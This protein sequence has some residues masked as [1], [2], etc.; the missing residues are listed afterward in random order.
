MPKTPPPVPHYQSHPS[1]QQYNSG[2]QPPF[3]HEPYAS[4]P[5]QHAAMPSFNPASDST[6]ALH[7]P[8]AGAYGAFASPS[9]SAPPMPSAPHNL[10]ST[11][12]ALSV[13]SYA[14]HCDPQASSVNMPTAPPYADEPIFC[15]RDTA[16][17]APPPPP[18]VSVAD[19]LERVKYIAGE[20][21]NRLGFVGRNALKVG[22]TLGALIWTA[23]LAMF[24]LQMP[25][26]LTLGLG[27]LGATGVL[28]TAGALIRSMNMLAKSAYLDGMRAQLRNQYEMLD[29]LAWENKE[30]GELRDAT[31]KA[32]DRLEGGWG[33]ATK[34]ALGAFAAIIAVLGCIF[35]AIIVLKARS[36]ST[37]DD[38]DDNHRHRGDNHRHRPF[39]PVHQHE[40]AIPWSSVLT[41]LLWCYNPWPSHMDRAPMYSRPP[42]LIVQQTWPQN[43]YQY[44]NTLYMR[45]YSREFY[46]SPYYSPYARHYF[47]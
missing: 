41:P 34:E 43:Y 46:M 22:A 6:Y 36:K 15:P 38:R 5:D 19:Q 12:H 18:Y 1:W 21:A 16:P 2:V 13:P 45:N 24:A 23:P 8:S 25:I 27:F 26:T 30:F 42:V 28:I 3:V 10:A 29:Q 17:D 9:P 47:C 33:E 37:D 40:A 31:K 14:S 44:G 7:T 32:L 39:L 20:A 35:M 4:A 11:P